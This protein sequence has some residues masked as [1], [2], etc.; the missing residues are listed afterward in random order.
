MPTS[1]RNLM[2]PPHPVEWPAPRHEPSACPHSPPPLRDDVG[3]VPYEQTGTGKI[4]KMRNEMQLPVRL[5]NRL[6]KFDYSQNGAYFITIC[7]KDREK[8]L[9]EISPE[10]ARVTLLPYG[11]IVESYLLNAPEIMKYVIMPDHIHL[12]ILLDGQQ[13]P[14]GK[15]VAKIIRS[16]KTLTTK[17]I[18]IS[19]FQR[20]Y[21]DHII[22]NRQDF[23]HVWQYIDHNPHKWALTH[24]Q[25]LC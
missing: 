2:N 24:S 16:I 5:R 6:E 14:Y 20:S 10:D 11:K 23:E 15:Q 22:R 17:T 3:I 19:I 21:Y 13:I 8:F 12:I 18:G 1:A 25:H 9:S 4:I 7:T